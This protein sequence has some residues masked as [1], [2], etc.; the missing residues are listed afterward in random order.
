MCVSLNTDVRQVCATCFE[1]RHGRD[2]RD[3]ALYTGH[4]PSGPKTLLCGVMNAHGTWDGDHEEDEAGTEI[5]DFSDRSSM[6]I[7]NTGGPTRWSSRGAPSA[8]DVT[9][10]GGIIALRTDWYTLQSIGSDHVPILVQIGGVAEDPRPPGSY[11]VK[12]CDWDAYAAKVSASFENL[13]LTTGPLDAAV[14]AFTDTIN[15]AFKS[16]TPFGAR[17]KT[18]MSSSARILR[19]SINRVV[20][21]KEES[22]T[23]AVFG[24]LHGLFLLHPKINFNELRS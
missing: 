4:W 7:L 18:R 24:N 17:K 12:K 14:R 6:T 22:V 21:F 15:D 13:D 9:I 5:D 2:G 3:E 20:A 19:I 11:A 16:S 1:S 10:A 23:T 8:P